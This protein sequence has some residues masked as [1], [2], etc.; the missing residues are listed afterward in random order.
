MKPSPRNSY[1][2]RR[3]IEA[4]ALKKTRQSSVVDKSIGYH[5]TSRICSML[6]FAIAKH[7]DLECR[8]RD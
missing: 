6:C 1:D 8:Y 5:D 4:T 3:V 7:R 2:R